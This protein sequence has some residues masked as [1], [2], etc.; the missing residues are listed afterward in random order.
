MSVESAK[1]FPKSLKYIIFLKLSNV[2]QLIFQ[3]AFEYHKSLTVCY[4]LAFCRHNGRIRKAKLSTPLFL[5]NALSL[6]CKC[7]STAFTV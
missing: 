3:L 2:F 6:F 7:Q 4:M 1:P 5:G